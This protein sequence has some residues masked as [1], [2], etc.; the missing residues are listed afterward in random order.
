M[1]CRTFA[2]LVVAL[3]ISLGIGARHIEAQAGQPPAAGRG[4]GAGGGLGA[5]PQRPTADPATLERGK[6]LFSVN[7]AFCHGSDARGAPRWC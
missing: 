3:T 7:C 4:R 5:Y 2:I 6:G 1:R